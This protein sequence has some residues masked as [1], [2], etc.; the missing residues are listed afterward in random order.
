[1]RTIIDTNVLVSGLFWHG[2]P[3]ALLERVRGGELTLVM[4]TALL[5]EVTDVLN[6]PKFD[7]VLVRSKTS[8]SRTLDELRRLAEIVEAPPLPQPV[9]RDA[10]DDAILAAA[11]AAQADLVISG[12]D[13]LLSLKQYRSIPILTPAEALDLIATKE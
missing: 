2:A 6:R 1:M 8:L 7:S 11:I 9:C 3:H 13:D 10:D 4:S 12:D 5:D